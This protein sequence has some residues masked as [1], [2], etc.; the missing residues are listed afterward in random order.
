MI[1]FINPTF[2]GILLLAISA[3]QYESIS[4]KT[5]THDEAGLLTASLSKD[6]NFALVSATGGTARL[7]EIESDE[8][9]HHWQHTD[10]ND[11]IIKTSLSSNNKYAITAERNSLA[12][13]ETASGKIIGYWDFP[14]ITSIALSSDGRRA[15]I[16]ME[17]NKAYYFDLY[18]GKIIH[19]FEHDGFVNTVALSD[20]GQYALT[21]GNDQ[22]AKLWDLRTG[23][24]TH[25]WR[26]NFKIFNVALSDDGQYA[27]SNASLGKTK[28]WDTQTGQILSQLPMRYMTVSASVFSPNSNTL[29]TGRPNQRIDLWDVKSGALLKTWMPPK[30]FLL[31]RDTFAII[32]LAFSAD[33]NFFFSETSSG[34][35]KKWALP[36]K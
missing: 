28:L 15:V 27:M 4:Y 16:G 21:G 30:S 7:I 17:S 23:A 26:Q 34:I 2:T 10:Q 18:Y 20:N 19:T 31:S 12:L 9:L 24:I 13:W 3:C 36:K 1:S 29:L 14:S 25:Q 33:G 8:T 22:Y 35:A 11:G 5:W 6:G 32:A